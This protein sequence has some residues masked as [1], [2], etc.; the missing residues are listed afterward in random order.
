VRKPLCSQD[1]AGNLGSSDSRKESALGP[2]DLSGSLEPPSGCLQHCPV[3][4]SALRAPL[5][6]TH[7]EQ[8]PLLSVLHRSPASCSHWWLMTSVTMTR[9]PS[10]HPPAL[11]VLLRACG[12]GAG[13]RSPNLEMLHLLQAPWTEATAVSSGLWVG[14]LAAS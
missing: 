6:S 14:L 11:P 12:G 7:M 1:L 4:A 13:G 10:R 3:W 5:W 9:S 2:L 8:D